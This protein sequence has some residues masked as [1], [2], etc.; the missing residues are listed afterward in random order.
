[1]TD[2]KAQ[3]RRAIEDRKTELLDLSHDIHTHPELNYQEHYSADRAATMLEGNGFEIERGVGSLDTAFVARTGTGELN[4]GICAEYDALPGVGHACGHNIIAAAAVGA[5]LGLAPLADELDITVTVLGTPAEEGGGGKVL[6]LQHGSFDGLNAA[7]MVHAAAIERDAMATLA[8]GQLYV[9]FHGRA[10]HAAAAPERGISASAAMT[11]AQNGIALLR[12]HLLDSDRVHGIV[13]NGGGAPNV[14]P[15]F[16]RGE[17]FVRGTTIARQKAVEARVIDVFR[18]AALMTGC[19]MKVGKTAPSFSD[20]RSD[21]R[22]TAL[23][24]ANARELGRESL[25][26]QPS[27]G[28]ASTDMGN[29]SYAVPSIHPLIALESDGANIHEPAFERFAAQATGDKAV[30]DGATALAMTI[31][32]M[33]TDTSQRSALLEKR[34]AVADVDPEADYLDAHWDEVIEFDPAS[35][36]AASASDSESVG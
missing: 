7:V 26:I 23:W 13:T 24:R 12:E 31:V 20:L 6:M 35:Y 5:A 9:E 34:Y 1:M 19:S 4:I 21:D 22:L 16:T 11:L 8:T 25:P 29:V 30:I 32:D 18:G 2:A 10:A 14:V 17:W 15:P 36:S 28:R 3:V 27:D 33:A